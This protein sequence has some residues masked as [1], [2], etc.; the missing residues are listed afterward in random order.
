MKRNLVV[1]SLA[2]V[3]LMALQ[4]CSTPVREEQQDVI[5]DERS[6]GVSPT[7]GS[8]GVETSVI[9]VGEGFF[10]GRP[11]EEALADPESV[12]SKRVFYFDFDSAEL[13]AADQAALEVHA[14]FLNANPRISVVLEGHTDERGSREYN[15][16]LGERRAQTI[17]RLLSLQGVAGA[18]MQVI[19]FGEERPVAL[20][21]H[22][23]AWALNRRV[24]L[25]YSGY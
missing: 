7:D 16:A 11:I 17:E 4:G 24:E 6:V 19:S 18:Q 1:V 20:G 13:P 14:R 8:L 3:L 25:L 5:V 2:S 22:E 15:L 10:E 9:P 21:H 23:D 12:L